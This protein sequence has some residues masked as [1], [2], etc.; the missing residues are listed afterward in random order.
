MNTI[1]KIF[2]ADFVKY[3]IKIKLWLRPL[4]HIRSF[5]AKMKSEPVCNGDSAMGGEQ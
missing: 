4:E 1:I 3:Y 5:Q 2:C